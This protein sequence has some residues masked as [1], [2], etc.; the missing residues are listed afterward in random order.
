MLSAVGIEDSGSVDGGDFMVDGSDIGLGEGF[1]VS[2]AGG[3]STTWSVRL[4]T[5]EELDL[6]PGGHAG[7]SFCFNS[8]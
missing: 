3:D 2:V 8:S 5:G 4:R 7:M 1:E 6:H